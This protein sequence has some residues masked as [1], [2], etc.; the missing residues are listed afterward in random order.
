M[1]EEMTEM[2]SEEITRVMNEQSGLERQY[3]ELVKQRSEL[4]GLS[5]KS[6]LKEVREEIK[7]VS[8]NLKEQTRILCRVLQ[9]NPDVDGNQRKIK[10]DK[11][12]L[13]LYVEDLMKEMR[14]LTYMKAKD[15]IRGE[16]EN[17]GRYDKLRLEEQELNVMIKN[18][19]EEFK[20][21]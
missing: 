4:K 1:G 2:M 17:Q 20:K 7:D 19:N 13:S 5:N 3:A 10:N 14:D 16:I 9:D 18:I 11:I 21:A 8:K 15:K 12:V 6:K